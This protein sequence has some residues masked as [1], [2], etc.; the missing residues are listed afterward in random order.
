MGYSDEDCIKRWKSLRDRFVREAKKIKENTT[1]G[2]VS[3]Y[4]PPWSL[5]DSMS[6]LMDSIR[7][8]K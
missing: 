2:G 7:H 5:F 6:F 3:V 4:V 8:R 1:P